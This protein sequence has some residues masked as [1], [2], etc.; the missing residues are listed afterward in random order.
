MEDQA[1]RIDRGQAHRRMVHRLLTHWRDAQPEGGFPSLDAILK[2]DLGNILPSIF[3]L[4]VPADAGEPAFARV[5]KSFAGVVYD[6]LTGR[7]V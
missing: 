3:V 4:E 6:D 5:G 2:R 1:E 7:P